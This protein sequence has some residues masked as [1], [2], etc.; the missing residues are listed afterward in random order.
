M[1]QNPIEKIKIILIYVILPLFAFVI[2]SSIV[3]TIEILLKIQLNILISQTIANIMFL[4][5]MI[6]VF[7]L[8]RKKY[9]LVYEKLEYRS[10]IYMIP[11]AISLSLSLNIIL[12][13]ILTNIES[14]EVS[15][16]LL[17]ISENISIYISVF[18]VGLITPITEEILF[19]GFMYDGIKLVSNK[20]VAIILTAMI[21]AITHGNIEQ[22]IYA[23]VVG[24]FFGYILEKYKNILYTI[25]IHCAMNGVV[26]IF[27]KDLE[28]I[29]E[30]KSQLFLLIIMIIVF[31]LT[32][33]RLN[34]KK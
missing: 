18:I 8:L 25:V 14:N 20:Y 9:K 22:G 28:N 21:F 2:F 15:N 24:L 12:G 27:Q 10:L 26:A 1:N 3:A 6:P 34:I 7:I 13:F 30:I 4:I 33:I 31:I 17:E 29:T 23:L 5:I 16:S 11:L 32:M 19:R